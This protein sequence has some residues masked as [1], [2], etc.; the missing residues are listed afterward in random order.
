MVSD[1]EEKSLEQPSNVIFPEQQTYQ[2]NP[3]AEFGSQCNS[4][5]ENF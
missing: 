4:H 3:D 2:D 5:I 1:H